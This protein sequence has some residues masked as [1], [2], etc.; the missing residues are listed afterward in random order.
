[1]TTANA[2]IRL[3]Q[4]VRDLKPSATLAVVA[5][6]RQLKGEGK[7]VIG[8]GAGEPDFDTPPSIRAAAAAALEA[9]QT[10][11][12]PVP[13]DPEA[14]RVIAEKLRRENGIDCAPEHIVINAGGKHSIYLALQALVDCGKGHEV[15]LPT[16]A[17]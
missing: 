1:M 14:R 17:G 8:F 13:G 3:S 9:G 16:P 5:R 2:S 12:M 10:R 7:D 4:R 15:I 11:Y 6:V